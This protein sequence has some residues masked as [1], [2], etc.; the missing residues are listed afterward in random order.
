MEV[1]IIKDEEGLGKCAWCEKKIEEES[2]VYG[3]GIKFRKGVDLAK[4]EGKIIELSILTRSKNVPMM[5]TTEGSEAKDDGHDAMFMTC[6]NECG[7]EMR[8]ALLNDKSIGG[9][10]DGVNSLNN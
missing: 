5:I 2:E 9:M 7:K 3:F 6:S 1:K 4:Y 8:A 10:F